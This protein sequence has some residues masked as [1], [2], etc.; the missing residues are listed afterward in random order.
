MVLISLKTKEGGG[1]RP[2]GKEKAKGRSRRERE[3]GEERRRPSAL[4]GLTHVTLSAMQLM[5]QQA[6]RPSP[7]SVLCL[8]YTSQCGDTQ[9]LHWSCYGQHRFTA[10]LLSRP[11]GISKRYS[12]KTQSH[13]TL[14]KMFQS[15]QSSLEGTPSK[16]TDDT[17]RTVLASLPISQHVFTESPCVP[18][19]GRDAR[20]VMRNKTQRIPAFKSVLQRKRQDLKQISCYM[21]S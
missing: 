20:F 17:T 21:A 3:K 8:R 10:S 1:C 13:G 6:R 5:N 12:G 4:N 16:L 2:E 15:C 11:R 14:R 9:C 19:L 7:S 18:G